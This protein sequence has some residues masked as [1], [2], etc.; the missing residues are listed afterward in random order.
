MTDSSQLHARPVPL[1][2]GA[3]VL[4]GILLLTG[5]NALGTGDTSSCDDTEEC[6]ANADVALSQGDY[7]SAVSALQTARKNSPDNPEVRA[8]LSTALYGQADLD[9]FD[10]QGVA[11]YVT[12][13][14]ESAS[15]AA[16]TKTHV[17]NTLECNVTSAEPR[18]TEQGY[19]TL[20]LNSND[21]FQ[22]ISDKRPTIEEVDALL[23]SEI[24]DSD[25]YQRLG[26]FDKT[27]WL[28]SDTFT[29]I[30]LAIL[31]VQ[32]K[33]DDVGGHLYQ[34]TSGGDD[35][36]YCAPDEPTLNELQCAAYDETTAGG[37]VTKGIDSFKEKVRLFSDTGQVGEDDGGA[38]LDALERLKTAVQSN[39]DDSD[40][41]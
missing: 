15:T 29:N 38:I 24:K 10:L 30:A 28:T 14:E 16:R 6:L 12:D 41:S 4:V 17:G 39:I 21:T 27:R 23:S 20:D 8:K 31:R 9:V 11:D 19:T 13:L 18:P 35:V 7:D 40:C 3:I 1:S 25:A 33:S 2:F 5:C 22:K 26:E 37:G 34:N 36:V 32:A